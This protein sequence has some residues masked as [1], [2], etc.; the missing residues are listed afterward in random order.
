MSLLLKTKWYIVDLDTRRVDTS[1]H[2]NRFWDAIA[3]ATN[4][5]LYDRFTASTGKRL[6]ACSHVWIIPEEE[7][8]NEN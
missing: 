3:H 7:N 6:L 4:N 1:R 5:R 8:Q 2:F